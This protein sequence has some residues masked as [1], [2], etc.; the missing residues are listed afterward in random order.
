MGKE[1]RNKGRGRNLKRLNYRHPWEKGKE[2]TGMLG[3]YK[4]TEGVT[5]GKGKEE[6][7][8]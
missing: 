3:G 7:E 6:G 1:S 2:G 5:G 8:R 4:D